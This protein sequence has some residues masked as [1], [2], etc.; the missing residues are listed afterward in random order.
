MVE[1]TLDDGRPFF[2]PIYAPYK[3]ATV[4]YNGG[5]ADFPDRSRWAILDRP[6]DP[7][8]PMREA[9][10]L[11]RE[12]YSDSGAL[13]ITDCGFD[14]KAAFVQAWLFFGTLTEVLETAGV[15][16]QVD[17]FLAQLNGSTVVSTSRLH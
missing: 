12:K 9:F 10:L 17:D 3:C 14:E 13:E 7:S 1:P 5:F 15:T 4:P 8:D 16:L 6:K 2:P 11:R